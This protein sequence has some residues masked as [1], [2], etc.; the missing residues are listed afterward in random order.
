[1]EYRMLGKYKVSELMLGTVGLG[2]DYGIA[3]KSGR[4][5]KKNGLQ[6]LEYSFNNGIT[7]FDTANTYGGAEELIG[8]FLKNYGADGNALVITK[9]K[10]ESE[11]LKEYKKTRDAA[12]GSVESSLKRLGKTKIPVCLLHM[13]R[14]L[15]LQQT[16]SF[17]S[18][19][20]AEL[21]EAGLVDVAGVSIDHP[22]EAEVFLNYQIF[23]AYQVPVNIFDQRLLKSGILKRMNDAGKLIVARSVFLQGLFFIPPSELKESLQS[24]RPYLEM[25]ASIAAKEGL[26][27]QQLAFS[28]I[29]TKPE[30]SSI[31]FGAE[32]AEQVAQNIELLKLPLLKAETIDNIE[33]QFANVPEYIITPGMWA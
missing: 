4:P 30:I 22:G 33:K 2:L 14:E 26:S 21:K 12:F 13:S 16:A 15:D 32:K 20:F 19:I 27:I 18:R 9:F 7:C 17:V 3:N 28:Y 5:D 1:M 23:E 25:L 29:R 6:I 8:D 11:D 10:I 31:V 24:A